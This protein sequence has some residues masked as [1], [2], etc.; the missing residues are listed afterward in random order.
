[1]TGVLIVSFHGI[2]KMETRGLASIQH[3]LCMHEPV[4]TYILECTLAWE[5]AC[6]RLFAYD[7]ASF[8]FLYVQLH[9]RDV[10]GKHS[11]T[12][13]H[14]RRFRSLLAFITTH[15]I[16]GQII[17]LLLTYSMLSMC[18]PRINDKHESKDD[19]FLSGWCSVVVHSPTE[20]RAAAPC[21]EHICVIN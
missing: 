11:W 14:W 10:H 4:T 9:T 21:V 8:L 6:Y 1:M 12:G 15:G 20:G 7:D 18:H 5:M 13:K 16:P 2:M 19:W 17:S 3:L